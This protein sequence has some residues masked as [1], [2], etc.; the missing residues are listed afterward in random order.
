MYL[1][2]FAD[3]A[4][5]DIDSQ[6]IATK[7][8]G[9]T[10]IEARNING[11]NIHDISESEFNEVSEKLQSAGVTI[12]CFGS[13]IANWGKRI[14]EPVTSSVEEARRAIP[15]MKQL[16]T[17]LV[18]IMSFGIRQG[19]APNDQMVTERVERLRKL[20]D[21]FTSE[22]IVPVHEN[23]MNYGGMGAEFTLELIEKIP[24]LKLVFDTG[25]PPMTRDRTKPKPF[26]LQSSWD[27]YKAVKD[28]I[29]YIHIKDCRFVKDR[30]DEIFPD[31]EFVYPGEGN[32]EVKRILTD[33]IHNGYDGGIS[34]E[35]HLSVVF[36]EDSHK[37]EADIQFDQ[38]VEYG[39]RVE[40]M[41]AEIKDHR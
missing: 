11:K 22:G 19:H 25:N 1:T 41:I 4:A 10:N 39:R 24:G 32:G 2:G 38:Y 28:H 17:K 31:A 40:T 37:A 27:F 8:L 21:M 12:N 16:E 18:R 7:K 6:I 9:W 29:A 3:E 5:P 36:H 30:P 20:V 13:A 14:D 34:I 23:C 15:R 33:L 26:P 35:P